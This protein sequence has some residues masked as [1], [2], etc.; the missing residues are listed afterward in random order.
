MKI[1]KKNIEDIKMV[2][3]HDAIMTDFNYNFSMEKLSLNL[4][5][6]WKDEGKNDVELIFKK[7]IMVY[8]QNA[9][10][11]GGFGGDEAHAIY[12][13]NDMTYYKKLVEEYKEKSKDYVCTPSEAKDNT[14]LPDKFNDSVMEIVIQTHSGGEIRILCSE[15]I[16]NEID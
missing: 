12:C 15:I 1:N 10:F 14:M 13:D 16:V 6:T 8:F 4:L 7:V 5:S 9:D 11:W 2:Y 3:V